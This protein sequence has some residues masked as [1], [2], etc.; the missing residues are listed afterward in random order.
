MTNKILAVCLDC[1]DTL[2]DEGTEV[3]NELGVS[4]RADLI[5]GAVEVMRRLKE[6]KYPLALVADGP[7]A[8]FVNNLGP[9]GLYE[10]FDVYAISD[11][12]GVS[13]P[14]PRIFRTA[15]D[16]LR[17][18]PSD[19]GR[20]IMVGNHLARDIKGANALGILSVWLDWAPRRPK[21]PADDSEL[22]QFTIHTLLEL[23]EVIAKV[24]QR[25]NAEGA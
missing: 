11:E 8:T 13:K 1:G 15:L 18:P 22:P 6:L 23:L 7:T 24:E 2:V 9:Y 16:Q 4:L 21:L 14:D 5:P 3:K 19:Y 10:L 12:L 25:F 20:V 17:I